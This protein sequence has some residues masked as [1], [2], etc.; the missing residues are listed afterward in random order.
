MFVDE[1]SQSSIGL[2]FESHATLWGFSLVMHSSRHGKLMNFYKD[3]FETFL[4][5]GGRRG[6]NFNIACTLP[7]TGRASLM[8][9]S[10]KKNHRMY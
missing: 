7:T 4:K 6:V 10:A 5:G 2:S 3:K 1:D 8:I 9:F